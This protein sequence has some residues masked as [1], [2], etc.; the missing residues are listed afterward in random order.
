MCA[1]CKT[2]SELGK[3]KTGHV[4]Q[5]KTLTDPAAILTRGGGREQTGSEQTGQGDVKGKG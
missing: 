5:G 4:L 3:G 1:N 2:S